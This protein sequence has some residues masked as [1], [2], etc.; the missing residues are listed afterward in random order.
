MRK[1]IN[2]AAICSSADYIRSKKLHRDFLKRKHGSFTLMVAS[3]E[4]HISDTPVESHPAFVVVK[5]LGKE[6][7]LS[8]ED[9]QKHCPEFKIIRK[10]Y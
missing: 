4:I 1:R 10:Y 8:W 9:Y 6:M 3:G 2:P 7:K 5:V